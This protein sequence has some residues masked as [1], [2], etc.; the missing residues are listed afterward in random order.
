MDE[1]HREFMKYMLR[2]QPAVWGYLM[3]CC[4]DVHVADDLMQEAS[5]LLW[6]RFATY[7]RSRPFTPWA[8]GFAKM[9]VLNW[10]KKRARSREVLSPTIVEMMADTSAASADD[11]QDQRR[12]L[13]GCLAR[14]PERARAVLRM[15]Y[16][17]ER[18]S[19]EISRIRRV[20]VAAVDNLLTRAR[21]ALRDCINRRRTAGAS[22]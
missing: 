20:T 3:A 12:H 14:L 4:G 13:D 16:Y 19:A 1:K 6:D 21:R 15:R 22:S 8:M 10:R 7:D 17:E 5:C 11:V 9:R 2:A 18:S